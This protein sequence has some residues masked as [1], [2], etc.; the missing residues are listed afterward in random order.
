MR[1][2]NGRKLRRIYDIISTY[3]NYNKNMVFDV[4]YLLEYCIENDIQLSLKRYL[5][6]FND[7]ETHNIFNSLNLNIETNSLPNKTKNNLI[8]Y[9]MLYADIDTFT[10]NYMNRK[11]RSK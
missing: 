7:S 1:K 4:D 6:K 11:I 9:N 10:T 5:G 3:K 2:F 8:T